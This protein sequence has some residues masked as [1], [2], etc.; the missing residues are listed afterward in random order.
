VCENIYKRIDFVYKGK[1]YGESLQVG[2]WREWQKFDETYIWEGTD[3]DVGEYYKPIT[4]EEYNEAR[5]ECMAKLA[6][7][8]LT[9]A[10]QKPAE[11]S[12]WWKRF[13]YEW[14]R[15]SEMPIAE[16]VIVKE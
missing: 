12:S 6:E 14:N 10:E 13:V 4:K 15:N 5:K 11:N 1:Y 7:F 2:K 3:I 16:D 9:K 8:D